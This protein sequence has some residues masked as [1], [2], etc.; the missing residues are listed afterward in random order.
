MIKITK[1]NGKYYN[2]ENFKH[3]GGNTALWHTFN[4]DSTILF[5]SY[6]PFSSQ[7]KLLSI[8]KKYE[9][10]KL[11]KNYKLY[12]NE[13]S[14]PKYNFN[15]KFSN[16]LKTEVKKYFE[17]L[18]KKNKTTLLQSVKANKKR[19]FLIIILNIFRLYFFLNWISGKT[20]SLIMYPLTTWIAGANMFH[21]AC[22]FSLSKYSFINDL[23]SYSFFELS[24]PFTWYHQHN[25]GHH[26]YTNL[27]DKDPD[28][29]HMDFLQRTTKYR[30]YKNIYKYQKY[31]TFFAWIFSYIG[32][33][34]S[35]N[36]KNLKTNIYFKI[37][38]SF[39][40]NFLII[41]EILHIL[42]GIIIS[43]L[44]LI[45]FKNIYKSIIFII[46]P[47]LILSIL[48]MINSQITHIHTDCMIK[49][50]DWY[51]NQIL[52]ASNHSLNNQFIFIFSGGLNYQIEHHLFP[53]VNHCHY[54]K[55]KKIIKKICIKYNVKYKEFDGYYDAF[56]SHYKHICLMSKP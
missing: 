37:I 6:H 51:K 9:I 11:P 31:T 19:W 1:I 2:L 49:N 48:F 26:S 23:F 4:R 33:I 53:N 42:F 29:Y 30:K 17:E 35:P 55:I 27:E 50:K 13:E 38:P 54:P 15:T 24:S 45:F 47:K 32:L 8:L 10:D 39:K 34:I 18:C 22:H 5:N 20:I 25:I 56:I 12:N 36:I 44:P 16:E 28:L 41:V 52:T 14:V 43:L 46:V 7:K 21:D 40:N 3:P